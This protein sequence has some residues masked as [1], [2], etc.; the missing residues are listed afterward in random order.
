MQQPIPVFILKKS[1]KSISDLNFWEQEGSPDALLLAGYRNQ[2]GIDIWNLKTRRVVDHYGSDIGILSVKGLRSADVVILTKEGSLRL[3]DCS[4]GEVRVKE[5][6]QICNVGFCKAS[7]LDSVCGQLLVAVPGETTSS[8]D[9]WDISKRSKLFNLCPNLENEKFGMVM[10][11]KLF[12]WKDRALFALG[13]YENGSLALWCVT[14]K[15][16]LHEINLFST[17]PIMCIDFD[18]NSLQGFAAG[19]TDQLV[20]F[21]V[22]V[23]DGDLFRIEIKRRKML[24]NPG[25]ADI[26]IREDNKIVGTAGWDTTV[27]IFGFRSCKPLAVLK[28]H[29]DVVHALAFTSS[30]TSSEHLLATGSSDHKIAI[31]KIYNNL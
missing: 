21:S 20:Q 3:L 10:C 19:P 29:E 12:I 16:L 15:R 14:E 2:E 31:W 8:V 18:S 26:K 6:V 23:C 7:C 25:I 11:V 24:L 4:N 30:N 5:Q 17:E 28:Y 27:R 22:H 1:A 9:V 13:G